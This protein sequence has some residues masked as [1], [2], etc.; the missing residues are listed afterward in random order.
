[1][2][3]AP[4]VHVAAALRQ[5]ADEYDAA[6]PGEHWWGKY[7]ASEEALEEAPEAEEL[8]PFFK[9]LLKTPLA[10]KLITTAIM[11]KVKTLFKLISSLVK[12]PSLSRYSAFLK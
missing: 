3:A 12:I 1:M 8:P 11:I 7:A 5:M 4:T 10:T 9:T 2:D 6:E